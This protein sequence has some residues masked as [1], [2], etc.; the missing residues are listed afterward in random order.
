[1]FIPQPFEFLGIIVRC[2]SFVF[3]LLSFHISVHRLADTVCMQSGVKYARRLHFVD[4]H[5]SSTPVSL[6]S[7]K[8]GFVSDIHMNIQREIVQTRM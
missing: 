2:E 1:M 4:R 3:A 5:K 8:T 6:S 7:A